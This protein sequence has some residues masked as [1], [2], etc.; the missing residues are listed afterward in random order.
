M[1]GVVS[2]GLE[3]EHGGNGGGHF[4]GFWADGSLGMEAGRKSVAVD[5]K[6]KSMRI[7]VK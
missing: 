5:E 4:L 2:D 6:R 1:Y 3:E 7:S